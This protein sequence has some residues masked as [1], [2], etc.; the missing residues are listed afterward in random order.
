MG[1]LFS[2][3]S[4]NRYIWTLWNPSGDAENNNA[5]GYMF[6]DRGTTNCHLISKDPCSVLYVLDCKEHFS[7][8]FCRPCCTSSATC[9]SNLPKQI[10]IQ[11]VSLSVNYHKPNKHK[12]FGMAE[13][14]SAEKSVPQ[15]KMTKLF[16]G[17]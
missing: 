17:L 9:S 1:S 11:M 14:L 3:N 4:N 6:G 7:V 5:D 13:E 10:Q 15:A 12:L 2:D 8:K 16:P